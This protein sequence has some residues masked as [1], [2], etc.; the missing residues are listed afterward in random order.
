MESY[1][2]ALLVEISLALLADL[3]FALLYLR[4]PQLRGGPGQLILAQTVS[5]LLLD[6]HWFL[7]Y[8][9]DEADYASACKAMTVVAFLGFTAS[10][11]YSAAICVAVSKHYDQPSYPSLWRYHVAVLTISLS[12]SLIMLCTHELTMSA[13]DF[14]PH[15]NQQ[16]WAQ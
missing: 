14:C 13:L 3:C 9:I 15:Y 11:A 5:Q 4:I 7:L 12:L 2:V 1:L 6:I 8:Y 10:C 16:S